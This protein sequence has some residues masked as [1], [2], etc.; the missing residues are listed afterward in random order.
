MRAV[1][2]VR[3]RRGRRWRAAR[4]PRGRRRARTAPSHARRRR[5]RR[6]SARRRPVPTSSAPPRGSRRRGLG[7]RPRAR[8]A[9]AR[10]RGR[11]RPAWRAASAPA[12]RIS[13]LAGMADG[14]RR[15][16]QLQAPGP[17]LTE[18]TPDRGLVEGQ[19]DPDPGV[20]TARR[21]EPGRGRRAGC[22]ARPA[23]AGRPGPR[24]GPTARPRSRP[25]PGRPSRRNR[26]S[27]RRQLSQ[28]RDLLE[29]EGADGEQQPV[30]GRDRDPT[31]SSD[32]STRPLQQPHRVVLWR[33]LTRRAPPRWPGRRRRGTAAMA[34]SSACSWPRSAGRRTSRMVS[35]Q[36]ALPVLLVPVRAGG[37]V[38]GPPEPVAD[39]GAA[40]ASRPARRPARSPSGRPSRC[41]R[42]STSRFGVER[43]QLVGAVRG[44][45][46]ARG[47]RA[48]SAA[49][50]GR[51]GR[52]ASR[53][54]G[55][56]WSRTTCSPRTRATH[57][58]GRRQH[59]HAGSRPPEGG[60]PGRGRRRGRV[61][62][63][64]APGAAG[65]VPALRQR[66]PH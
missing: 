13:H 11:S 20:H 34:R 22:R 65:V 28:R 46:R 39:R 50:R 27:V 63:C 55:S 30:A 5:S 32:A 29:Q 17:Q 54:T 59:S 16:G 47:T 36:R 19:G 4:P 61:R 25:R 6:G 14:L 62:S 24:Q 1:T 53:G 2:A 49:A 56:G 10:P 9:P 40:A 8:G 37:Q 3:R 57:R 15:V 66:P 35:A 21:R 64:P 23:A 51:R 52:P 43:G 18:V 26:S 31:S 45:G 42:I 58:P 48:R 38:E 12:P 60:P 44:A 41:C 33:H 7:Q